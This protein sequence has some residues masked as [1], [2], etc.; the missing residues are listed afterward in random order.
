MNEQIAMERKSK[1]EEIVRI[2][3]KLD[4]ASQ[5]L[6]L[7]AARLAKIQNEQRKESVA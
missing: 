2:F 4:E 3:R 1:E 6:L 7:T 5:N